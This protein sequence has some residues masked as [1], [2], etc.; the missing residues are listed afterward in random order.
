MRL[1]LVRLLRNL[2]NYCIG[3]GFE[4]RQ[5]GGF[6][7]APYGYNRFDYLDIL[8]PFKKLTHALCGLRRPCAVFN[9]AYAALLIALET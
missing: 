4:G 3:Q 5:V 6:H 2:C 1:L 9:Q 7:A 8:H